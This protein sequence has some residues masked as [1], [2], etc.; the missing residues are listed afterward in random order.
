MLKLPLVLR[1]VEFVKLLGFCDCGNPASGDN[2]PYLV[3]DTGNMDG[4]VLSSLTTVTT[5]CQLKHQQ[6]TPK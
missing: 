5:A 4:F 6:N 3:G 1:E 2:P